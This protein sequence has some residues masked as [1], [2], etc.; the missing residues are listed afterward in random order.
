MEASISFDNFFNEV[1]L[2]EYKK[3]IDFLGFDYEIINIVQAS[4]FLSMLPLHVEN[5]KKVF[6]LALRSSEICSRIHG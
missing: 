1:I 3:M 5:K 4:L 2:K 6:I